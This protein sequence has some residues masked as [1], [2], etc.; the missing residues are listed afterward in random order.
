MWRDVTN[1]ANGT[2]GPSCISTVAIMNQAIKERLSVGPKE[3]EPET[4]LTS[5]IGVIHCSLIPFSSDL[6]GRIIFGPPP[7]EFAFL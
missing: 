4:W 1:D 5:Y 3:G 7:N 6:E 2:R